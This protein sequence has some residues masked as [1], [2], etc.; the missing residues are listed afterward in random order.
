MLFSR[1]KVKGHSM[2][3]N[4]YEG[5]YVLISSLFPVKKVDVVVIQ[6][7]GKRMLKRVSHI[8]DSKYLVLSDNHGSDSRSFGPVKKQEILGKVIL[9]FK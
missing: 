3:P 4:Y 5:D 9:H 8:K 7:Q 6:K 1:F 2:E